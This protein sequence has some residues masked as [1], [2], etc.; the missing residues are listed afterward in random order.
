MKSYLRFGTCAAVVGAILVS[1]CPANA[2][3]V[4]WYK[5][6]DVGSSNYT[7]VGFRYT[8]RRY[9]Y[10]CQYK[11]Y[12]GYQDTTPAAALWNTGGK[13]GG[14]LQFIAAHNDGVGT[15]R[16]Y[17]RQFLHGGRVDQW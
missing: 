3:L 9:R 10:P 6:D 12:R 4:H 17:A 1:A 8:G 5:F 16:Q 11:F 7:A 2:D 14:C 13:I 15:A